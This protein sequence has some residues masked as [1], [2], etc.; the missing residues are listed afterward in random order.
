MKVAANTIKSCLKEAN[1]TQS[2]LAKN[3]GTSNQNLSQML[4][5]RNDMKVETFIDM[6]EHIGYRVE[7]IKNN[8]FQKVSPEMYEEIYESGIPGGHFW[9]EDGGKY[10]AIYIDEVYGGIVEEFDTKEECIEWLER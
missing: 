10:K 1:M 4:R 8:G 9:C 6:L 2:Q 7:I 3:M 5:V